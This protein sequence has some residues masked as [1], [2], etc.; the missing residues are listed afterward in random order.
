MALEWAKRTSQQKHQQQRCWWRR[1]PLPPQCHSIALQRGRTSFLR[2]TLFC[3]FSNASPQWGKEI[4]MVWATPYLA[5]AAK[6]CLF[7]GGYEG[8]WKGVERSCDELHRQQ[9]FG[10]TDAAIR[11]KQK[12]FRRGLY[13][14]KGAFCTRGAIAALYI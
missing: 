5:L 11:P 14:V 7:K 8:R 1:V 4:L 2:L 12:I 9:T 13:S 10:A 6:G 3:C